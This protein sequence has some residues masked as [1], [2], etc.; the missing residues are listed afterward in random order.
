M[1]TLEGK[2]TKASI[3]AD[4][5]E[6]ECIS[7]IY[8]LINHPAFKNSNVRIMSDCHAGANICIGFTAPLH[9]YVDIHLENLINPPETDSR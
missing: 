5:I 4:T 6:D 9:D 2:Y 1:I 8:E 7:Q 3:Y